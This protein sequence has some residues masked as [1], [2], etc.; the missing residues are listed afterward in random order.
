MQCKL[1]D[2]LEL[3][4]PQ[5]DFSLNVL[6]TINNKN[7]IHTVMVQEGQKDA[8]FKVKQ[9]VISCILLPSIY[10]LLLNLWYTFLDCFGNYVFM[11]RM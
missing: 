9:T 4:S 8:D 10:F 1:K 2:T 3:H 11:G 7:L 5:V 6:S